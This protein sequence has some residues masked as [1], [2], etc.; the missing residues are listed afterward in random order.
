MRLPRRLFGSRRSGRRSSRTG[1]HFNHNHYHGQLSYSSHSH[2][3][4]VAATTFPRQYLTVRQC[5]SSTF[6][7]ASGENH[8]TFTRSFHSLSD[9]I[10]LLVIYLLDLSSIISLRCVRSSC[11]CP[12]MLLTDTLCRLAVAFSNFQP[13]TTYGPEPYGT[14]RTHAPARDSQPWSDRSLV[15]ILRS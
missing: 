12:V 15:T 9:D 13:P 8:T 4:K 1:A 14:S 11:C 2:L 3:R 5:M 6:E 10:I 7:R